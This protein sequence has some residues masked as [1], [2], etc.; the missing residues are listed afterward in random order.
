VINEI[1]RKQDETIKSYKIRLFKNKDLYD[2]NSQS[3][4]DLINKETG[5]TFNES[6]YRKWY[7][8]YSDK[9]I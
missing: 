4:A 8:S 7:R 3:I 6:T 5:D 2:L 1:N 9:A